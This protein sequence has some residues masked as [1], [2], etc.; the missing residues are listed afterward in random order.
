MIFPKDIFSR[1]RPVIGIDVGSSSLKLLD[2]QDA[3]DGPRLINFHR[4]SLPAGVIVQ[5]EVRQPDLLAEVLGELVLSCGC[6]KRPVVTSLSG[7]LTL[8]KKINFSQMSEGELRGLLQDEGSKYLPIQD[9][10][11]VYLDFQILKP[12]DVNPN[13][14]EVLIVAAQRAVVDDYTAAFAKAGLEIAIMDVDS[15][16]LET[17]YEENYAPEEEETVA[18]LD[19]GAGST[20]V[21]VV[22]GGMSVFSRNLLMGC[23]LVEAEYRKI[24]GSSWVDNAAY[25]TG[26]VREPWPE[27]LVRN[28]IQAAEQLLQEIESSLDY[29][30]F[31]TR[32]TVGQVVI[33]GGGAFLPDFD[34]ILGQRLG[35]ETT[36]VDP[37]KKIDLGHCRQDTKVLKRIAPLVAVGVGLALRRP[38]D[39]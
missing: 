4:L 6:Q 23:D 12:S 15:Y 28:V 9:V 3:K 39:K 35:L 14:M 8:A 22:K 1:R 5:G 19:I 34:R 25:G 29:V 18:L 30:K 13:Q 31:Q 32:E 20:V 26:E 10:S 27:E 17:M 38:D 36:I 16:A 7:N 24:D 21:N 2:I 37:L 11:D 33:S